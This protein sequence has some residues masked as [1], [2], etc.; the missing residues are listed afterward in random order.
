L[1]ADLVRQLP[2]VREGYERSILE[3]MTV[4]LIETATG[5]IADIIVDAVLD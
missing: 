1:P 5:R 2:P 4:V 3:D